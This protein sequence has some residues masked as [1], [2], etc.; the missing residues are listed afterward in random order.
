MEAPINEVLAA[1][2][3]LLSDWNQVSNF[4]DPMCGSGTFLIEQGNCN[5][6]P[7]IFLEKDLDL[8]HGKILT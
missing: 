7:A 4:Y 3:I 5:N 1:G 8:K 2:L 6:I